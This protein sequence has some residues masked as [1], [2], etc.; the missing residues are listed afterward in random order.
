MHTHTNLGSK[1]P[2]SRTVSPCASDDRIVVC[3]RCTHGLIKF[4]SSQTNY[5]L[6]L[7]LIEDREADSWRKNE[8]YV[9]CVLVT[10]AEMEISHL[11]NI[12]KK[13]FKNIMCANN[14]KIF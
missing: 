10:C 9:K 13:F 11:K 1:L 3:L 2:H 4:H 14:K 8:K 7:N 5:E 12:I 6:A